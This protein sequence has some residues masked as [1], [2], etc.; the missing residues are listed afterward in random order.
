MRPHDGY[1]SGSGICPAF[2][3]PRRQVPQ[4]VLDEEIAAGRGGRVEILC[5]QP[6]RLAAVGV[7]TRVA[8]ER[9][10]KG[11]VGDVVGYRIRLESEPVGSKPSLPRSQS[12]NLKNAGGTCEEYSS[13]MVRG[14]KMTKVGN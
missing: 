8:Q 13:E 2:V 1:W 14:G 7:A 11:G 3:R 9:C 5:T 4:F 10:D 12:H 6:R